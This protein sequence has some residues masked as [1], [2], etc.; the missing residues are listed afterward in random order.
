MP[1]PPPP[2]LDPETAAL[3]D[4]AP[5][6]GDWSFADVARLR[7]DDLV[8]ADGL[9]ES[10]AVERADHDVAAE[11]GVVVRVHR[12]PGAGGRALPCLYWI[13]GGGYV[14]GN[15]RRNGPLLDRWCELF[16][17]VAVT[18]EYR[19]APEHP[20]PAPLED[21]YA[22]LAWVVEQAGE[23]GVDDGAIGIGGPSAG[24]GLT[25]AL[26]LLARDRAALP[27]LAFQLLIYPMIDDRQRSRSSGWDAPIWPARANELGWQAYLGDLHGGAV[28]PYAAPARADELAGLP[29]AL[30]MVGTAD[31]FFDEDVEYARRLAHAGV[32]TELHVY[33]GA[34]HGFYS[35]FAD[36]ELGRRAA[37]DSEEWLGAQLRRARA[38]MR[39]SAA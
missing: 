14:F 23:L 21:C 26:A 19:L 33:P 34:P 27:P 6:R 32:P 35:T 7:G 16:D 24:G 37:R 30:V 18:V 38:G 11:D 25:A 2:H 22:G 36:T 4:T 10:P 12:P 8:L 13:H 29:P 17:C 1:G 28:P 15:Y 5:F 3:L 20:Y 39:E 9:P 31:V